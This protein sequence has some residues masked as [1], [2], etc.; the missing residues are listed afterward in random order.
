MLVE[1]RNP[2]EEALKSDK[3]VSLLFVQH[4]LRDSPKTHRIL[5]LARKKGVRI[6]KIGKNKINKLSR[7]F[8]HQGMIA[9][10]QHETKTLL[11]ILQE[12]DSKDEDPF[13]VMIHNV[14]YQQ[15]LGAIIRSAECAGCNG[16]I[17]NTSTK[18]TPEAIRASM[19]ATEH[20]PII[21]ESTFNAVK[22]LQDNAIPIVGLEASGKRTI[23]E[24]DLTGPITII[25]GGEDS[26]ITKS[27][28]KKCDKVL[29][30]PLYGKIES[31]NMSNSA[32]VVLFEKVRQEQSKK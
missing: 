23:Y 31:L 14:L 13:F 11:E 10:V 5:S 4:G 8:N 27:L 9:K 24:E 6:R 2:V 16:I 20:I 3:K 18:I 29:K 30:I 19:G 1:G 25:V 22:M 15:N 7:T 12:L 28:V 17:V 21:K 32:A 26:G